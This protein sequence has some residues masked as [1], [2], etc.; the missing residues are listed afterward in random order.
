MPHDKLFA[1]NFC[2]LDIVRSLLSRH[3]NHFF[4]PAIKNYKEKQSHTCSAQ[5]K[6]ILRELE[7]GGVIEKVAIR[8]LAG[9]FELWWNH[10]GG[11]HKPP[12]LKP[13][14]HDQHVNRG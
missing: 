14:L 11:P 3:I 7:K 5:L 10:F 12:V 4:V 8:I 9:C 2:L 6:N 1:M 13:T